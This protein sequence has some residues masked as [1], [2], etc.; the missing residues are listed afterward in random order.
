M[1]K[2]EFKAYLIDNGYKKRNIKSYENEKSEAITLIEKAEKDS[3]I[4]YE[5][6]FM[7]HKNTD[8]VEIWIQRPILIRDR[9]SVL[10]SLNKLNATYS[11][12][13]YCLIDNNLVEKT[14]VVASTCDEVYVM[15]QKAFETA[16]NCFKNF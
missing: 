4:R 15:Y 7:F 13:N 11:V 1:N 3:N 14:Y 5:T 2:E 16:Q 9:L 10:E 12:S 8:I 6:I